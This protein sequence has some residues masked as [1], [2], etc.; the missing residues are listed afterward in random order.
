[1]EAIARANVGF[2][3][4][5]GKPLTK[6]GLDVRRQQ[7]PSSSSTGAKINGMIVLYRPAVRSGVPL[8]LSP[9]HK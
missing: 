5:I 1:M 9:Q 8:L 2:T 7:A 6:R 4:A 3:K